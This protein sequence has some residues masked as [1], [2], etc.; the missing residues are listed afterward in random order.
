M[1]ETMLEKLLRKYSY[2]CEM[3]KEFSRIGTRLF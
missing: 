2:D 3:L 1:R